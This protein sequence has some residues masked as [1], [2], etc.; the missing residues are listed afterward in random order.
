MGWRDGCAGG[1]TLALVTSTAFAEAARPERFWTDGKQRAVHREHS[2][3]NQVARK[4]MPAVVAI[5]TRQRPSA[6]E[7]PVSEDSQNG[8]GAG[9]I[10]HPDGYILT[11]AHVIEDAVEIKVTVRAGSARPESFVAAVVGQDTLTDVALLKIDAGRKLPVLPLGSVDHVDVADWVVVIGNPF[12]LTH[13]VT[14][15]VVSFKGRTDVVPSGRSGYYDYLQTDA[16]INPGNSGGPILNLDGEV[17]AIANAVNVAGQGI[18]FAVPID[19]A[20]QVLPALKAEGT[21]RRGW[22]GITVQDLTPDM[23]AKLGKPDLSGVWVA[24]VVSGGPA[25][26]A[27]LRSGDVITEVNEAPIDRASA[28][29]WKIGTTDVGR[30]VDL[31]VVRD[32]EPLHVQVRLAEPPS[33]RAQ[34]EPAGPAEEIFSLPDLLSPKRRE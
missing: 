32:G 14:V 9:F 21:V 28:L 2:V 7:E 26:R 3:L 5:S 30:L 19:L 31:G 12:G 11:S 29:R 13:S 25:S 24:D 8:I 20:K 6:S 16:P 4:A 1:L 34:V 33:E 22:I 18:G 15:G 27:G 23:A 10:I 17:V